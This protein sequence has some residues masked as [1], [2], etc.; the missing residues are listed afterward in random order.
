MP[1][2]RHATQATVADGKVYLAGG[3]LKPGG[4]GVTDQTIVFTMP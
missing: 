3:S 2:G 4:S 1:G